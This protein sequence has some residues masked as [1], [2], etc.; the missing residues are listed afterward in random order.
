MIT[1]LSGIPDEGVTAKTNILFVGIQILV[2]VVSDGFSSKEKKVIE[3]RLVGKNIEIMLLAE[4]VSSFRYIT[5]IVDYKC[6][7]SPAMP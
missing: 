1:Y 6:D 7:C 2:K 5:N 4:F 3:M